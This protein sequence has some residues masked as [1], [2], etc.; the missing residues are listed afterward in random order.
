MKLKGK[1]KKKDRRLKKEKK[2][3]LKC[4]SIEKDFQILRVFVEYA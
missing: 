2:W 4:F 1:G 3:Q